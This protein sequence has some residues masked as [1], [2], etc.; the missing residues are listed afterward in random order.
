MHADRVNR[1]VIS[2]VGTI[3]MA[4]GVGGLLAAAGVFGHRFQHR[5]L[6]DNGLSRYVGKHGTWLW[7]AI[8][9]VTLVIVLLALL[10]LIRLLFSTDRSSDISI[11]Q[12]RTDKDHTQRA[13]GRTTLATAALS[14]AVAGEIETYHGVIGAKARV[15]G[16]ASRPTLAIQVTASRHA[17]LADLTQRIEREAVT[18]ARES[19]EQPQLAVK[20]DMAVTDKKVAR[21]E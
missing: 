10:W 16:D 12:T 9:A 19:L 1:A 6:T 13:A 17:E 8:A 14:Q 15:L 2:L 11:A 5:Q 21:T 7:P 4:L 18:H 20:L 3:A